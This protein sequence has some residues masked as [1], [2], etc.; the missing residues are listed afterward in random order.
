MII[1]VRNNEISRYSSSIRHIE[2]Y[3]IPKVISVSHT[4]LTKKQVDESGGTH[5]SVRVWIRYDSVD[6]RNAQYLQDRVLA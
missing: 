2:N 5:A 1:T 6:K 3:V 4:T